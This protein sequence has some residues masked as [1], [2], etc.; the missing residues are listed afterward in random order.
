MDPALLEIALRKQRL[1]L[2]AE[3]QRDDMASRLEAFTPILGTLDR[4]GEGVDWARRHGHLLAGAGVFL[5]LVK[6]RATVRWARRGWMGWK[7]LLRLRT[8]LVG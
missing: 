5:L 1:Q 7:F 8:A 2:R 4:M 6:P 3:A